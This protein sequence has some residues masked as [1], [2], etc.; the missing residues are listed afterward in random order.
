MFVPSLSWQN[1]RFYMAHKC[2]FSHRLQRS[3]VS[4][5]RICST[6]RCAGK[7]PIFVLLLLLLVLEVVAQVLVAACCSGWRCRSP[8]E[9]NLCGLAPCAATNSTKSKFPLRE[10]SMRTL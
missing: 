3:H 4:N 1:V 2:R 5:G 7:T 10:N 9:S 8:A 6:Y